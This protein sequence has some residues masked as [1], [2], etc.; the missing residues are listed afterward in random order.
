MNIEE[1][2]SFNKVSFSNFVKK[3]IGDVSEITII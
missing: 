3:T 1:Y 2:K